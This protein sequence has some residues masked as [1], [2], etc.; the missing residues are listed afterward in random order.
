ME[1]SISIEGTKVAVEPTNEAVEDRTSEGIA[2]C[3]LCRTFP[4][5]AFQVGAEVVE[6][7]TKVVIAE[8]LA[9]LE[10]PIPLKS[11]EGT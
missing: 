11:R 8:N 5:D 9:I 4:E 1:I 6:D 10:N 7:Q 3:I 2:V